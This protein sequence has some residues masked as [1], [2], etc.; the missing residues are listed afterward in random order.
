MPQLRRLSPRCPGC[1]SS[2]SGFT[3]AALI[4]LVFPFWPAWSVHLKLVPA[5]AAD[6]MA[7][8]FGRFAWLSCLLTRLVWLRI[9]VDCRRT[10]IQC[11]CYRQP[12]TFRARCTEVLATPNTC[13]PLQRT[14]CQA[15]N[16][17]QHR[18][19]AAALWRW[20]HLAQPAWSSAL[21]WECRPSLWS[22]CDRD[23]ADAASSLC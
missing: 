15:T 16:Q 3:W 9:D 2:L 22:H 20:H 17:T 14:S 19:E 10:Q 7:T 21:T 18:S 11:P 8:A 23:A 5:C 6:S 4:G 13:A 1:R 12:L